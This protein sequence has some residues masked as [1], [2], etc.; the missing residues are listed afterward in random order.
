MLVSRTFQDRRPLTVPRTPSPSSPRGARQWK[1]ECC[2][3]IK[4]MRDNFKGREKAQS[5]KDEK[6]N[7]KEAKEMVNGAEA[8]VPVKA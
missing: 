3:W 1:E 4:Y 5:V 6:E 2:N 7:E 8:H